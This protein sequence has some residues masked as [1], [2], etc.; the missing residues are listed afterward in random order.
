M[1][2]REFLELAHVFDADKHSVGGWFWSEKLDGMRCFWDGGVTR[3]MLCAEVPFANVE[4]HGRFIHEVRSTGLWSRYGQPVRAPE[5]FLDS[6]PRCL[7]DGELYAGR[8]RFQFVMDTVK[9][10]KADDNQWRQ[11]Q[12]VIFGSPDLNHLFMEGEIKGVNFKKEISSET[13]DW[14]IS[15][16]GNNLLSVPFLT[17]F[18]FVL[19][20]LR[21]KVPQ[22]EV[23]KLHINE[24]LP[25]SQD[26]A[27]SR[28]NSLVEIISLEGGEGLMIKKPESVW[29]PKRH[30]ELLKVKKL[31]DAEATVVGYVTGRE[32]DKGSKLLGLMGALVVQFGDT[33]FELSGFTDA[34]RELSSN[35]N[36]AQET[37]VAWACS[38]PGKECPSWIQSKHFPRGSV[39]SFKYRE[40]SVDGVPKEARYWR[41]HPC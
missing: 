31:Q 2:K 1:S 5:W 30:K 34:E 26:A 39:I 20:W 12:Y 9:E 32:T 33:R 41:K 28:I 36:A 35:I 8:G 11:I 18:E 24:R 21:H 40:L 6:L 22:N 4:K 25:L 16:A 13:F 38:N 17:P 27:V 7:L 14:F 37:V 10:H 29:T 19:T 3:G 15:K 23:V